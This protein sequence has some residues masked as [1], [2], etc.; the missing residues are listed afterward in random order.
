MQEDADRSGEILMTMVAVVTA[1]ES[2]GGDWRKNM[3]KFPAVSGLQI[4]TYFC[5]CSTGLCQ[6]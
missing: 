6:A 3:C 1:E 5:W 4:P 2:A